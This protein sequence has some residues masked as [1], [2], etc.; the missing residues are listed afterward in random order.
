MLDGLRDRLLDWEQR[1]DVAWPDLDNPVR[2]RYRLLFALGL[3]GCAPVLA[4]VA[5]NNLDR[6]PLEEVVELAVGFGESVD[7]VLQP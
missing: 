4:T 7:D 2:L 5:L 1:A 6:L 3:V